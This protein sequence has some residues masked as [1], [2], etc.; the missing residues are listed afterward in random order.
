MI[1]STIESSVF[2]TLVLAALW[3]APIAGQGDSSTSQPNSAKTCSRLLICWR[4]SAAWWRKSCLTCSS[5]ASSML[6]SRIFSS[7]VCSILS[8]APSFQL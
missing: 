3:S 5:C 1:E 6:S 8:A 4:V 7:T 2:L